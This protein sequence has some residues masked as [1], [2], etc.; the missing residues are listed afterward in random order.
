MSALSESNRTRI[1]AL[2]DGERASLIHALAERHPRIMKTLLDQVD[3]WRMRRVQR[4]GMPA[5]P[6]TSHSSIEGLQFCYFTVNG[7]PCLRGA[8][9]PLHDPCAGGCSDPEAH[10]EGAHD[11]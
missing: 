8:D 9:D 4:E 11:V 7:V 6:H 2:T 10:A 3:V 1:E 5:H